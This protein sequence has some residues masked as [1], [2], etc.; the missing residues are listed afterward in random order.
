MR[1]ALF[2]G[3]DVMAAMIGD[4][5]DDRALESHATGN[6]KG[7]PQSTVGFEGPVGEVAMEA[8]GHPEAAQ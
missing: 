3:E 5:R 1:I 7:D 8:S 6:R 4:P 2:V